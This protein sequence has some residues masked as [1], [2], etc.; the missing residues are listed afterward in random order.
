MDKAIKWIAIA[1]VVVLVI[2]IAT[3][4]RGGAKDATGNYHSIMTGQK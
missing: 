3:G 2:A 1:F 4:Y